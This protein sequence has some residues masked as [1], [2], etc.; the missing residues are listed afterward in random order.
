M[1]MKLV[2]III[3]ALTNIYANPQAQGEMWIRVSEGG[4]TDQLRGGVT[5]TVY[6]SSWQVV[7]IATTANYTV[8]QDGNA[9]MYMS[10]EPISN[11]SVSYVLGPLNYNTNYYIVIDNKYVSLIIGPHDGTPDE[12]LY[13]KNNTFTLNPTHQI[14]SLGTEGSWNPKNITVKN[15]FGGGNVKIDGLLYQNIGSSGITK[16]FGTPTFPHTLEAID[17]QSSGGYVLKYQNWS[18]T[19][20][21]NTENIAAS[22]DAEN[23]IYTAY[24]LKQF[25]LTFKN[26]F[27]GV[28]NGGTIKVNG[29]TI[30]SPTSTYPVVEDENIQ[31]SAVSQVINGI[32]YL[33]NHWSDGNTSASRTITPSD[34]ANFIAYFNGKPYNSYRGLHF[35]NSGP[36]GTPIKLYWNEHPNTNVTKYQIWRKHGKT[37][38][39]QLIATKNRGTTTFTDY[40][41]SITNNASANNLTWYDVRAYYSTEN[42]YAEADYQVLYGE[43]MLKQN[44]EESKKDEIEIFALESNYPN[45]F[46]PTTQISYQLPENSFVNLVVYNTIGQKVAELVN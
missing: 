37:G 11:P 13:F 10:G 12:H 45:P 29:N 6:N 17:N 38:S 31:V 22:I 32:E 9:F 34:N 33:F 28:G 7:D 23:A 21:Y 43:L 35:N 2:F 18:G 40:D 41:Y 39:Y 42:S 1:K 8:E 14:F 20:S 19:N 44:G 4:S 3:F 27:V 26:S 46:N 16:T 5:I 15:S 36:V 25:N 24:F 30:S